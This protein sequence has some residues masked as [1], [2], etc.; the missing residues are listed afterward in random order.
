M[1]AHSVARRNRL[2]LQQ[3]RPNRLQ[4]S[5]VLLA[6]V[7]VMAAFYAKADAIAIVATVD[8][9]VITTTDVNERRALILSGSDMPATEENKAQ[10]TPRIVSM[11]IDERL[12][13]QEAKRQSITVSDAELEKAISGIAARQNLS[14]DAFAKALAAKGASVRSL[15]EQL[16]AQL[17]WSKIVQRTLRRNVTISQDELRRAAQTEATA[18][19]IGEVRLAALIVPITPKSKEAEIRARVAELGGALDAGTSIATLAQKNA[20]AKDVKFSAPVWVPEEKLSEPLRVALQDLKPGDISK[21]TR[22]GNMIQFIQL[23]ERRMTKKPSPATEMTIKQLTLD[24]PAK[25]DKDIQARIA[26][27]VE[28]LGKNPGGCDDGSV[29]STKLPVEVAFAQVKMGSV[30]PEQVGVLARLEVG[31]VSAPMVDGKKLRMIL[32]CE[33]REAINAAPDNEELKQ[34]LFGE[35]MELEAEK[36][37]RNL[38]REATIELR[39]A[40]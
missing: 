19:G 8:D 4:K 35:K 34:R 32:L 14:A 11:L 29:P 7:V 31:E 27:T 15:N 24:L 37:L 23:L 28:T 18:P 5:S 3:Q 6:V 33:R 10:I 30:A 39:G 38:R 2:L 17:A 22:T 40:Q 13:L 26:E 21:P 36:H 9:E 16:R 25:P 1:E 20:G 12:Q